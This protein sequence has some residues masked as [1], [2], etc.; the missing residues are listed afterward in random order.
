MNDNVNKYENIENK[1]VLLYRKRKKFAVKIIA[2]FIIICSIIYFAFSFGFIP[3]KDFLE[4]KEPIGNITELDVSSYLESYP[5]LADVP[6]LDKIKYAAYGTDQESSG[7]MNEYQQRLE[8]EG[9]NLEYD[10]AITIEGQAV[11]YMGFLKG[12]TAVGII[13]TEDE[14]IGYET[15]VLYTTGN[16]LDYQDMIQWLEHQV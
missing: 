11:R 15:V 14:D 12:L 13:M 5:E 10:G 2:F 8:D 9:Y 6:N 1:R 16:A 7:I 3:I 4:V